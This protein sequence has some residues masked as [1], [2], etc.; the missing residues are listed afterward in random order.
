MLAGPNTKL[1]DDP[2][3]QIHVVQ[4]ILSQAADW[5]CAEQV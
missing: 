5:A 2:T 3:G 1:P 4:K